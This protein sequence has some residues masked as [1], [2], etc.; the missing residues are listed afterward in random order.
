MQY[1]NVPDS[2]WL[3]IAFAFV[4]IACNVVELTITERDYNSKCISKKVVNGKRVITYLTTIIFIVVGM[5][6]MHSFY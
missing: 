6:L 4:V 2:F 1:L 3:Y 5:V